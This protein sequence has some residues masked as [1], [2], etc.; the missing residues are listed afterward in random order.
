M[1][2]LRAVKY[3]FISAFLIVFSSVGFSQD[4]GDLPNV[5]HT[6]QEAIDNGS[7]SFKELFDIGGKL[8][9]VDFSTLDG[10]G[11]PNVNANGILNELAGRV[12]GDKP[13]DLFT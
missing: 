13:N 5:K 2:I 8:F 7:L 11:R 6:E 1:M 10:Y 4:I 12:L 9:T 3:A